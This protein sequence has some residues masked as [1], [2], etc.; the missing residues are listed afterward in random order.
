MQNKQLSFSFENNVDFIN[1][2]FNENMFKTTLTHTNKSLIVGLKQF[3]NGVFRFSVDTYHFFYSR[4]SFDDIC[5]DFV[6]SICLFRFKSFYFFWLL[7]FEWKSSSNIWH[8]FRTI[9]KEDLFWFFLILLIWSPTCPWNRLICLSFA[10][11]P[12]SALKYLFLFL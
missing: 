8:D 3:W 7:H 11:S 1:V 6:V 12:L 5:V 2:G 4:S 9:H 10:M